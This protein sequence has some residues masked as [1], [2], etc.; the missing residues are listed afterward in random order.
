MCVKAALPN[1]CSFQWRL[2]MHCHALSANAVQ[3]REWRQSRA[4]LT[5]ELTEPSDYAIEQHFNLAKPTPRADSP[6]AKVAQSLLEYS[7]G[8]SRTMQLSVQ[9]PVSRVAGTVTGFVASCSM[10][11]RTTTTMV[12]TGVYGARL[13]MTSPW[14][15][16]LSLP[17]KFFPS[18]AIAQDAGISSRTDR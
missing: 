9:L 4:V 14:A 15:K 5:D 18:L 6:S 2:G 1:S 17:L 12:A 8:P 13:V 3:G 11:L 10:S 16:R 7:F